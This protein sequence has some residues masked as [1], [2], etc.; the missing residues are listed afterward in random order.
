MVLKLEKF[1]FAKLECEWL[2]YKKNASGITPLVRKTEPIDHCRSLKS[3]MGSIH[4]L[5]KYLPALAETSAPL[6]PL[7]SKKNDFVR[8]AECQLAFEANK[9]QIANIVELK[10]FDVHKD[11]HIVCDGSQ[12]RL[13]EFLSN[14]ARGLAGNLVCVKIIKCGGKKIFHVRV[15]NASGGMG[16]K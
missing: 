10:Q 12:N 3:F 15:G 4:R 2:G 13:G 1:N 9:T 7:L 11:I 6:R 8:L 16:A 5:D 14:R